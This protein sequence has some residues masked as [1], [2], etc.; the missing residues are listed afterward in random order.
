M[1]YSIFGKNMENIRKHRFSRLVTTKA[2]RNY[3]VSKAKYFTTKNVSKHLS[4]IEIKITQIFM[5]K[6]VYWALI[7]IK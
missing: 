1:N 6:A 2:G 4:A 5:N 3:L 7:M